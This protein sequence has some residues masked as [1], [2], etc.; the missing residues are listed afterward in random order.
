MRSIC[1][2][3]LVI[4]VAACAPINTAPPIP[5]FSQKQDF[6][7]P[8]I[9][10]EY[11]IQIGDEFS[12]RSYFDPNLDQETFVRPDGRAS[13]LL[14]GD[15]EVVGMT[16]SE[17]DNHI[18]DAYSKM[19]DAP[20]VVVIIKKAIGRQVYIGGEIRKP[21]IQALKGSRTLL[22]SITVAGGLLAT[23]NSQQILLLRR[24]KDGRFK[25]YLVDLDKILFKE[26]PDP[27]LRRHDVV[28]IPKSDIAILNQ[29]V[30]QYINKVIPR[31]VILQFNLSKE[32]DDAVDSITNN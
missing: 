17:L 19:L 7:L 2:L 9:E 22:Q 8:P 10:E 29:N 15:V 14:T 5:S 24:Q 12:V 23:A 25:H 6:Y 20:E 4:L 32:L 3:V 1:G 31:A 11:Q 18:T 13:L 27:Y 30:D 26:A 21:S 16:P 28:Y